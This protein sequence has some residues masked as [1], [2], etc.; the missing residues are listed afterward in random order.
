M[1][2]WL[3]APLPFIG[4]GVAAIGRCMN[5]LFPVVIALIRDRLK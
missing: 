3:I 1:I 4:F 2:N 5:S